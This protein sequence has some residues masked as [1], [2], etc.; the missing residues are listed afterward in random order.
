MTSLFYG[1]FTEAGCQAE[2]SLLA[3]PN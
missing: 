1:Y 2:S 3:E